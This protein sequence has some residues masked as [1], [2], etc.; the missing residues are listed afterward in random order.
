M[1]SVQPDHPEAAAPAQSKVS[2][3]LNE[4][5]AKEVIEGINAPGLVRG[6]PASLPWFTRINRAHLVMLAEQGLIEPDVAGRLLGHI[7][8]L[9]AEG[10]DAFT[11]DPEREDPWFNYE[12]EL[13][14]R[15]GPEAGRLHMAR[16]RNDLKSTQDR[17]RTRKLAESL[18]RECLSLRKA[19]IA[20][21]EDEIATIMPGYTHLQH[22]QPITFGW[23][24]LGLENALTRDAGRLEDALMRMDECPLGAGALAGTRFDIDRERVAELLG[25]S[26]AQP[27][28]L[29][30]VGNRDAM[31]ELATAAT[32][33]SMTIGRMCQD[34]YLWATFEFGMLEFPDRVAITSSIMPQKK[35]LAVLEHLKAR[36]A[37]MVG[38]LTTAVAACRAVP[39][40]HSQ[41]VGF[42]SGR[43]LWGA[44]EELA[45]MLPA[46]RVVIECAK[47]RRDRMA[48]LAGANFATAT[49]L[50]DLLS[51]RF[52]L[53][54]REAH[55]I[56]G[57]Y[58]RLVLDGATPQ[59]AIESA[60]MEQTG[61]ALAEA[62][63]LLDEALDPAS[64]L[65]ATTGCGP[66]RKESTS[67]LAEARLRLAKAEAGLARHCQR[68]EAAEDLLAKASA[69]YESVARSGSP[70]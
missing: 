30:A 32:Q 11:L 6:F 69:R 35:N 4:P 20:R 10:P 26:K 37:A 70:A 15:A 66:S 62:Q 16:S 19:L 2:G 49:T 17:M 9:D 50:A 54:F 22:A 45:E 63:A 29:D 68:Q 41:E 24:L 12:A 21:V 57:R 65:D 48:E 61:E 55:H 51:T 52:G 1:M 43:W 34:F 46:A 18:L 58:V 13:T 31:I 38:A 59:A 64:V 47:P 25:F 3:F 40:G 27:H 7:A 14:N 53:P 8:Q 33:L 28:S 56:T 36:P 60:Y 23:Y 5:L 39:F 44:V 67:L 42:E